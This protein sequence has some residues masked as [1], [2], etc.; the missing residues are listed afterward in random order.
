MA[1]GKYCASGSL[2]THI[3]VYSVDTPRKNLAIKNAHANGVTGVAWVE[4]GVL[5][6]SGAD[7]CLKTWSIT[8]PA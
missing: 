2:D 6:S 8:P 3:Y 1:D 4:E 7:G 5:V